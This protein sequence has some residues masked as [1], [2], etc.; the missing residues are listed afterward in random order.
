MNYDSFSLHTGLNFHR[1]KNSK[2]DILCTEMDSYKPSYNTK[3]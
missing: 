3:S 1:Q 2:D